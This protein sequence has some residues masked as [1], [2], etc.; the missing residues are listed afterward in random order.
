MAEG[1]GHCLD[2]AYAAA[3]TSLCFRKCKATSQENKVKAPLLA[4]GSCPAK[5]LLMPG[6]FLKENFMPIPPTHPAVKV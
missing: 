3:L 4:R 2:G 6:G 1:R 5:V